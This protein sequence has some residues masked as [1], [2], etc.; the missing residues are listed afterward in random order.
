M[1][2]TT[3]SDL[4]LP[5]EEWRSCLMT[6][7]REAE[8]LDHGRLSDWL[9]LLADDFE[10]RVLNRVTR[11]REAQADAFVPD[12]YHVLCDRGAME[13]RIKR[14][15]SEFAWSED[16]PTVTR[17][18]VS[19]MRAGRNGSG[20]L[21]IK[22]YLLLLRARWESSAFVSAERDDEWIYDAQHRLRLRRRWVYL[23]H[24]VLP[25]DN[26]AVFL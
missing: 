2:G 3:D 13:T 4:E 10:Y 23:D 7:F 26:L 14:L 5:A 16:T 12:N 1:N 19:N 15:Q 24:S 6:L 21:R 8:L 18:F 11:E 17:R 9:A 22:S 20:G 25:I